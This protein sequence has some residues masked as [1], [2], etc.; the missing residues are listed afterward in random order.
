MAIAA[1]EVDKHHAADAALSIAQGQDVRRPECHAS[2]LAF[3]NFDLRTSPTL[4]LG[5]EDHRTAFLTGKAAPVSSGEE[6]APW[7]NGHAPNIALRHLKRGASKPAAALEFQERDRTL[8]R[9]GEIT[10]SKA[11]SHSNKGSSSP[12]CD[13]RPS[14]MTGNIDLIGGDR[15]S[16]PG[17]EED[18]APVVT[19]T[20]AGSK[21]VDKMNQ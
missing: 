15:H 19:G 5:V 11:I 3:G 6:P 16:I 21:Y 18:Y 12:E 1:L 9:P 17:I 10:D 14:S 4:S 13:A 20:M 7:C 8:D 2:D